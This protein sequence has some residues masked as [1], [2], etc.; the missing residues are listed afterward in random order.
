MPASVCVMAPDSAFTQQIP[1]MCE[2]KGIPFCWVR[3]REALG[4]ASG[5]RGASA[6][7]SVL[8]DPRSPL[9]ARVGKMKT[10]VDML[11]IKLAQQLNPV[12]EVVSE[13][14]VDCEKK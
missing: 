9:E 14:C 3:S 12:S 6:A 4:A 5:L 10:R 2:D 13:G 8:A 7:V 1:V 11:G